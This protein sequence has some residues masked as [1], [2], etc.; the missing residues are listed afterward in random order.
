MAEMVIAEMRTWKPSPSGRALAG[1]LE[2]VVS[3]QGYFWAAC[4]RKVAQDE[5]SLPSEK[6]NLQCNRKSQAVRIPS[7]QRADKHI[8]VP[9]VSENENLKRCSLNLKTHSTLSLSS[10]QS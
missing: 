1:Q 6:N 7:E 5:V 9:K 3:N 4:G 8:L 10:G 2:A